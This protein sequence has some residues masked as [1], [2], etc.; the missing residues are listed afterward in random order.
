MSYITKSSNCI[1]VLH[2]KVIATYQFANR[3]TKMVYGE[4]ICIEVACYVS[5]IDPG[6]G[7]CRPLLLQMLRQNPLGLPTLVGYGY[8]YGLGLLVSVLMYKVMW[9]ISLSDILKRT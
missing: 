6:R 3:M 8:G 1:G 7:Q 2:N 5:R 9:R 4:T